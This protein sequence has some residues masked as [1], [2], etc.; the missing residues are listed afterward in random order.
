MPCV[1]LIGGALRAAIHLGTIALEPKEVKIKGS[2]FGIERRLA[3]I[4]SLKLKDERSKE[5][6]RK[7]R[8]VP[9]Y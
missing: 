8:S 7:L 9:F 4:E 6:L 3:S 5:A 2:V 1:A